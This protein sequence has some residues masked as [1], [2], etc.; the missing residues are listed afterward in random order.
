M[1]GLLDPDRLSTLDHASLYR[2]RAANPD[3]QDLLSKYEHRAF[4]R[5]ATGDNPL[6]GLPI[7]LAAPLYQLSK[8]APLL[9]GNQ[10]RSS[11]SWGQLGHGLLGVGEGLLGR[12][13]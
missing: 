1:P 10:S 2:M 3:L 8:L 6:M 9:T 13:K 12:L 7:A 5:E 11:P 4:A